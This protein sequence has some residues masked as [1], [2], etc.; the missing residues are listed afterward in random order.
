M[1]DGDGT[2]VA[3]GAGTGAG[4]A[5]ADA[6]RGGALAERTSGI[7]PPWNR[8]SINGFVSSVAGS[9]SRFHPGFLSPFRMI[10]CA[11]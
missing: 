4:G 6:C 5:Q 2:E 9:A 8:R 7:E 3:R 10:I 11:I 1:V